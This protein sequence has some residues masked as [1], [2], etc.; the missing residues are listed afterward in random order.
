MSA[1]VVNSFGTAKHFAD[2]LKRVK[3]FWQ[4]VLRFF[5]GLDKIYYFC[6]K[7]EI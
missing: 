6:S 2:Y 5:G 3:A 4:I 1:K 7:K